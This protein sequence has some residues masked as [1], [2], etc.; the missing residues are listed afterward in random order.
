MFA[1][2]LP[3]CVVGIAHLRPFTHGDRFASILYMLATSNAT[4]APFAMATLQS[5]RSLLLL[6]LELTLTLVH[7]QMDESPVLEKSCV[8]GLHEF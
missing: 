1:F 7:E 6:P 4:S 2:G 8:Q 3:L 5:T